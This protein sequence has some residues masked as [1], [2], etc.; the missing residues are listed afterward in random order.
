MRADMRS[1][2]KI[3]LW[4]VAGF[5]GLIGLYMI[6][7]VAL[8]ALAVNRDFVETR[9]GIPVYIR[10]NGVHA[11]LIL[12]TRGGT[13]DWTED[14]PVSHMRAVAEPMPWIAFG[15]GDKDFLTTT[16]TFA[17]ISAPTALSALT[18]LGQGAMHVEYIETPG[19]YNV[20]R[21][22]VSQAEYERLATYIRDSF[23]RDAKGVQRI[24]AGYFDNDAFYE[25]RPRYTFWYTC[26]EWTRRALSGAGVRTPAWAPFDTAIFLQL[27]PPA[28][29]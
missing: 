10:T 9:D 8:G 22:R 29:P 1:E 17:D 7:A 14:F 13:I 28:K 6:A 21:V 20:R 15:W 25:A 23:E 16:P 26:N 27:P 24:G 4:I 3:V 19:A 18:G 11:D 5:V 2:V 12:P